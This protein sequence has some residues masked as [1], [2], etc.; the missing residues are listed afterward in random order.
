MPLAKS[1]EPSIEPSLTVNQSSSKSTDTSSTSNLDIGQ[2]PYETFRYF[3]V[4]PGTVDKGDLKQIKDVFD[5]A[6]KDS[7][8]LGDSLYKIR[9]LETKLGQ[10]PL[11]ETRYSKMWNY[12]RM[13]QMVSHFETEREK[14]IKKVTQARQQEINRVKSEAAKK[15]NELEKIRKA[16]EA[17]IR[18]S[19]ESELKQLKRLRQAYS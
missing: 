4:N 15:A 5:W 8:G 10:P 3:G 6:N 2:V 13:S 9:Q 1:S 11:G 12:V 14:Q 7:H 19:R 17:S 16:E 18:K